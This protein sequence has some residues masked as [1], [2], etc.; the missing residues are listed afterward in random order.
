MAPF[1][2]SSSERSYKHSPAGGNCTHKIAYAVA[3]KIKG[4]Y[5][6]NKVG[7]DKQVDNAF[8][9]ARSVFPISPRC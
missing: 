9:Y 1:C 7:N 8:I 2:V 6:K 3:E 4:S 5:S